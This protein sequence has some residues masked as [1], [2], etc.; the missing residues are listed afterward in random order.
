MLD[1]EVAARTTNDIRIPLPAYEPD[2]P[3]PHSLWKVCVIKGSRNRKRG[4]QL[5]KETYRTLV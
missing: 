5:G 1:S 3:F 4:T 2:I